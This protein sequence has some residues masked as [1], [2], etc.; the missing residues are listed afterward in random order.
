MT[1]ELDQ[2]IFA[3]DVIFIAAI[4]ARPFV[5][6]APEVSLTPDRV[7]EEYTRAKRSALAVVG[8][9]S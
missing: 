1:M 5:E 3:L 4:K 8:S 9:P 7:L 2:F 6:I